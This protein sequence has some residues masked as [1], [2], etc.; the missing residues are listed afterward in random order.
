VHIGNKPVAITETGWPGADLGVAT[1][2]E[3]SPQAQV[4]YIGELERLLDGVNVKILNWLHYYQMAPSDAT[5][6]KTF[7]SISLLDYEGNKRPAYDAWI[8]FQP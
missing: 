4:R 5:F 8:N 6:W 2:W 3:Q 7:S 1:A